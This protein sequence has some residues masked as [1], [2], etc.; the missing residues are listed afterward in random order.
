MAK[1]RTQYRQERR[2][3]GVCVDCNQPPMT[4]R[5]YCDYHDAQR[6]EASKRYIQ[7]QREKKGLPVGG[8]RGW[9]SGNP[10]PP[11]EYQRR[12]VERFWKYVDKTPGLGPWGDCWEWTGS[13]AQKY[14]QIGLCINGKGRP[15]RAHAAAWVYIYGHPEPP[16]GWHVCHRCNNKPCVREEHLFAGTPMQ[17]IRHA[18]LTGLMPVGRK[19][20]PAPLDYRI[21]KLTRRQYWMI[22]K[23]RRWQGVSLVD[24]A[25]MAQMDKSHLSQLERGKRPCR[26]SQIIFILNFLKIDQEEFGL[27]SCPLTPVWA[28]KSTTAKYLSDP[29]QYV[30]R[31]VPFAQHLKKKRPMWLNKIGLPQV[32]L[33]DAQ[34]LIDSI[35]QAAVRQGEVMKTTGLKHHELYKVLQGRETN[36]ARLLAMLRYV[37]SL[38]AEQAA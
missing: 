38:K 11:D 35:E 4:G 28:P 24:L 21:G 29:P 12:L 2:E 36:N 25:H 13:K 19:Q 15:R 32:G 34:A 31:K 22:R 33:Y 8:R 20:R 3:R 10:L 18:Q 1:T 14:G 23:H 7:R 16:K 26:L 37:E 17:N 6:K 9:Y 5:Q 30:Y 27:A